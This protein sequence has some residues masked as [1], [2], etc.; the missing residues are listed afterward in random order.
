VIHNLVGNAVK[1]RRAGSP[2]SIS[3]EARSL[4]C[5]Q[6]EVSVTDDGICI[7]PRFTERV[8]DMLYRLHNDEE[9]EGTGIGLSVC[10]KIIGDH[11]GQIA[12]DPKTIAGT[13][14]V[15]TLLTPQGAESPLLR[16][17]GNLPFGET[18]LH[19]L[20]EGCSPRPIV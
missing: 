3:V 6:V 7:E 18:I 20:W 4:S 17:S 13:R 9:Y 2:A 14:V 11:G 5:D 16:K 12:I 8:F 1:F 10:R 19:V 15:F